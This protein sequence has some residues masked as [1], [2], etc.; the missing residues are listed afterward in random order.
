MSSS[1]VI[2]VK[3]LRKSYLLFDN[4]L[5]RL[6]Q[7]I[8]GRWQR[9]DVKQFV[10]LDGVS[11]DIRRGSTVG[12][13]GHNG[14]G[15]STLLQLICG[16]L[17]PSGGCVTVN[18]KVASLLE[19][20]AGFNPEFSGRENVMMQGALMGLSPQEIAGRLPQI[21][22]FA[23]IGDFID[24]PVKTYSSGMYVRLAFAAAVHVD[25]DILIVDEAL[26]VGDV[27]FQ[28]KCITRMKEFMKRGTVLFVSHD[29]TTI[30]A[31]CSE[32]IWL[33]RG[34]V[35]ESGDPKM[36][37]E[38]YLA[39][40][41]EQINRETPK[42][43]NKIVKVH[44]HDDSLVH[45]DN[46]DVQGKNHFG[47]GGA[48]I[49]GIVIVDQNGDERSDIEGGSRI[50]VHI[51]TKAHVNL[52]HPIIGIS[53]KDRKGNEIFGTNTDFELQSLPPLQSGQRASVGF[54][55]EMPELSEGSYSI[56]AAIGDGEQRTH[57][58]H[59]WV[60]DAHIMHVHAKRHV[61]G[62]LRPDITVSLRID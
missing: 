53:L 49:T 11:F 55:I 56:C 6:K 40:M 1:V 62:A 31:L 33:D 15:K 3:A 2:S 38:H 28:H 44:E 52:A 39:H 47:A 41:Y 43:V 13:I 58:M 21:E 61:M 8:F 22:A 54:S 48:A 10:A 60:N 24:R 34:K 42:T 18:G 59:H 36:V 7:L 25:P 4:P 45:R 46:L 57:Q 35:R 51:S 27:A 16:T 50:Q 37:A 20:G 12:I 32:V 29:M 14:S 26:A 23:E 5:E 9:R 30:T 17:T 19:L